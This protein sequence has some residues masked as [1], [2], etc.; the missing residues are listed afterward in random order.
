MLCCILPAQG[1]V[2]LSAVVVCGC[3]GTREVERSALVNEEIVYFIFQLELDAQL[4]RALNY[5][6]YEA[7][8]QIRS[9]RETVGAV[10]CCAVNIAPA[11]KHKSG[12]QP[13]QGLPS[14]GWQ[15]M[16]LCGYATSAITAVARH[17]VLW[18]LKP[19]TPAHL[20][21]QCT[22]FLCCTQV[23]TPHILGNVLLLL[24]PAGGSGPAGHVRAQGCL[25]CC[26]NE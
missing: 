11:I 15:A 14:V 16:Q 10:L 21:L 2:V 17:A 1:A 20:P 3:A 13:S 5:E 6:A 4:Q 19:F 25:C 24:L 9:K 18:S 12:F 22:A 7:A 26:L 23:L 8:Q